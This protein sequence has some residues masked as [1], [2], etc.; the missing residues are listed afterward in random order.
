MSDDGPSIAS[1]LKYSIA[2]HAPRV[3]AHGEGELAKKI[4]A[5]AAE[6]NIKIVQDDALAMDLRLLNIEQHIPERLYLIVAEILSVILK[7]N[8]K[9]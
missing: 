9:L 2:D 3:I 4:I 1:A 8:G 5:L 7:E 6:H